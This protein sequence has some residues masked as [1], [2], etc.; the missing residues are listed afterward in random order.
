MKKIKQ[1]PIFK[2]ERA[3]FYPHKINKT[4]NMSQ[5]KKRIRE[6]GRDKTKWVKGR[7]PRKRPIVKGDEKRRELRGRRE[8]TLPSM[9]TQQSSLELWRETSWMEKSLVRVGIVF[10][11][12]CLVK[13]GVFLLVRRGARD[14]ASNVFKRE[15]SALSLNLTPPTQ[16]SPK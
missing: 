12:L 10:Y 13:I 9:T 3:P 6:P 4:Q 5:E 16:D 1:M 15:G 14:S 8:R 11:V 2:L 7:K